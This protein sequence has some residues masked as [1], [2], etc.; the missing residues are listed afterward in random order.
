LAVLA[1]GASNDEIA[2]ALSISR[3]TVER[4]IGN[5]YLKIGA[6]NRAEATAYAYKRGITEIA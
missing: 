1:N 5:I 4:H 6:H 2:R 3:R